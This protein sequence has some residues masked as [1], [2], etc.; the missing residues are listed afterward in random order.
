MNSH[1][2]EFLI[3][4]AEQGLGIVRVPDF[5]AKSSL[6]SGS[7]VQLLKTYE[8]KPRG[9]FVVYPTARYLPHRTRALMDHLLDN[10]EQGCD[11]QSR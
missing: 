4:S 2:G 11:I 8:L 5:L 3:K 9:V 7:L 6:D 10:V 1:D